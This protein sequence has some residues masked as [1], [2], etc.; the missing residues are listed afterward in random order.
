MENRNVAERRLKLKVEAGLVG[1]LTVLAL[2]AV[3]YLRSTRT[4][5]EDL[6]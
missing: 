6:R 1:D 5:A 4:P 3:W 2:V